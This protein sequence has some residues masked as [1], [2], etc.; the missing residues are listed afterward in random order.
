[1]SFS[2]ATM[3][4]IKPYRTLGAREYFFVPGSAATTYTRGNRAFIT[5]T[6]GMLVTATD[7]DTFAPF[8]IERTV[9]CAAATQPFPR[10]ADFQPAK[11]ALDEA[12]KGLVLVSAAIPA[13]TPISRAKIKNYAD[14]TVTAYS[15]ASRYIGV[16]TGF[17]TDDR[18]NGALVYVYEG[19][20]A[21]EINIVEDYDH[22]GG[23]VELLVQTAR[24]FNATLTTASKVIILASAS[25]TNPLSM[26]GRAD[27]ADGDE[28]DVTDGY[29]DGD[30]MV[31]GGFRELHQHITN[32]WLPIANAGAMYI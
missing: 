4:G 18:P 32:G 31:L 16:T 11:Y 10:L 17:A 30:F 23:A 27:L 14:E 3:Q 22:T 8:T 19:P 29:D 25:G 24:P 5:P 1:M 28:L 12:S 15:A 20:G 9:T 2:V 6:T 26:F 13:G 7:G 21:G